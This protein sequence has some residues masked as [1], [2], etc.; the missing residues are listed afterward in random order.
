MVMAPSIMP[1][2]EARAEPLTSRNVRTHLETFLREA[3]IRAEGA[4]LPRFVEDEFRAFL[5]CEGLFVFFAGHGIT[6][7][8]PR[9]GEEGY[10]IGTSSSRSTHAFRA[11]P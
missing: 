3:A 5:T 2:T 7:K 8:L 1:E 9:G 6:V 4:G 11:S 10:L